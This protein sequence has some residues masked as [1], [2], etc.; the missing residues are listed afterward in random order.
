MTRFYPFKI[1]NRVGKERFYEKFSLAYNTSFQ[2]KI[3]FKAREFGE[4]GFFDK[5]K[6]FG[7]ELK[8]IITGILNAVTE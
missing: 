6:A 1:K 3:G 4:P 5:L 2:N 8:G 7:N